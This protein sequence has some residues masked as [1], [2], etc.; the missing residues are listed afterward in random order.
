MDQS[1]VA[2]SV[3][4]NTRQM[5]WLRGL[6]FDAIY[7][8]GIL[9][10][11][12]VSGWFVITNPGLFPAIFVLNAWL[13]GYHHVV[14]TFTRITFDKESLGEHRFLVVWLPLI[15][16]AGVVVA[17]AIF[18]SWVL[19]TTYLYWQWWHYTRQSY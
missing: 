14:S 5:G 12:L 4:I 10:A 18:G 17:W 6:S 7:I 16:L 2:S 9:A 8:L 1:M 19:T 13:L 3:A 15:M 11:A